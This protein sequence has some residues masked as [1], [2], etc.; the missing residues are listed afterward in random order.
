MPGPDFPGAAPKKGR[1]K[2]KAPA[3][4]GEGGA[5]ELWWDIMGRIARV[6][7][8]VLRADL[9]GVLYR[10]PA[11]KSSL[12]NLVVQAVRRLLCW[13]SY[14]ARKMDTPCD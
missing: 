6:L 4:D 14:W 1:G 2:T 13:G 7:V 9:D 8:S 5:A 3:E 10:V 11:E 12:L